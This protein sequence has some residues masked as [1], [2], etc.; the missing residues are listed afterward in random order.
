MESDICP[1]RL[2]DPCLSG[3]LGTSSLDP[4]TWF[5]ESSL[6]SRFFF[7][8]SID[9]H[10]IT[11]DEA[12]RRVLTCWLEVFLTYHSWLTGWVQGSRLPMVHSEMLGLNSVLELFTVFQLS[13]FTLSCCLLATALEG[14]SRSSRP[15][16][17]PCLPHHG[18]GTQSDWPSHPLCK[19][20]TTCQLSD[21]TCIL[22]RICDHCRKL[23]LWHATLSQC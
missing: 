9:F 12:T 5:Q 8:D 21:Y 3:C 7:L 15:P 4:G 23:I 16:L 11:W 22:Q 1:K 17:H 19:L 6:V 18:P 13:T 2:Y 20:H 10:G 14:S